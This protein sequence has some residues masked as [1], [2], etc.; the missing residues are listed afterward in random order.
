MASINSDT[1]HDLAYLGTIGILK[2]KI[3]DDSEKATKLDINERMPIHWAALGGHLEIVEY[4]VGLNSPVDPRDDSGA[5]PLL[6]ASSAGKVPVVKYLLSRGADSNISNSGG[7]SP[8]QYASSKGWQEVSCFIFN[9]FTSLEID[10]WH[11]ACEEERGEAALYLIA[12]GALTDIQNK[13]KKTAL[14]L[15]PRPLALKLKEAMELG[16]ELSSAG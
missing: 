16:K 4:L 10:I 12:K 9:S 15:A 5:T 6:L 14:E 8:L 3:N 7:H 1:L 13:E 11:L 2:Y